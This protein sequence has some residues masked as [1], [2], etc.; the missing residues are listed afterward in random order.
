MKKLFMILFL[1]HEQA[2]RLKPPG[3]LEQSAFV[4]PVRHKTSTSRF[5]KKR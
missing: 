5:E 1:P 3:P 4:R 2:G